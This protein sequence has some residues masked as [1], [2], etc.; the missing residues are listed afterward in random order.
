[1]WRA[2]A[3]QVTDCGEG[4]RM[5]WVGRDLKSQPCHELS[6]LVGNEKCCAGPGAA[7][8]P[9]PCSALGQDFWVVIN[10]NSTFGTVG[11]GCR[12]GVGNAGGVL[13]F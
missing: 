13:S 3:A 1:M 9:S 10:G 8:A 11:T 12:A 2:L 5:V 6:C 4:H 7:C